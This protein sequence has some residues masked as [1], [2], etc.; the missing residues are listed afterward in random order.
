MTWSFGEYG[1]GHNSFFKDKLGDTYIAYHAE[2]TPWGTP[3]S[4]A[5]RRVHFSPEGRPVLTMTE[6][7]E[8]PMQW[9]GLAYREN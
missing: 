1:P 2:K 7:R 3:R 6:E 9:W 5:L 4:A 8:V